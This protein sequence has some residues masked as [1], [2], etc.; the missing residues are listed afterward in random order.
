M[1]IDDPVGS[2]QHV[3]ALVRF[4]NI[5]G[6][7]QNRIPSGSNILSATLRLNVFNSG[8]QIQLHRSLP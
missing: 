4:D 2:G 8:N 5:F 6:S 3:Q 1:D 7:G